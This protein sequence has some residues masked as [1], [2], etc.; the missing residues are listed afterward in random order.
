[1]KDKVEAETIALLEYL[2]IR[3]IEPNIT[4]SALVS[5]T[6][7]MAGVLDIDMGYIVGKMMQAEAFRKEM[8]SSEGKPIH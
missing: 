8:M 6:V 5:A 4:I 7:T 2:A 3:D 1:M